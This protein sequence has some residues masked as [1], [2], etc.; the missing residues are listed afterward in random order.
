MESIESPAPHQLHMSND[1]WHVDRNVSYLSNVQFILISILIPDGI[2][3]QCVRNIPYYLAGPSMSTGAIDGVWRKYHPH[4][5]YN[6]YMYIT[7]DPLH[8]RALAHSRAPLFTQPWPHCSHSRAPGEQWARLCAFTLQG[9]V[10]A[11]WLCRG[12]PVIYIYIQK[13]IYNEWP[14]LITLQSQWIYMEIYRWWWVGRHRSRGPSTKGDCHCIWQCEPKNGSSVSKNL[15]KL[16]K[17][18]FQWTGLMSQDS[19]FGV[20]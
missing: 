6:I 5:V 11:A 13:I 16:C 10:Q 8:S 7:G 1:S 20:S 2:P 18:L 4:F 12:S 14:W 15:T 3:I 19:W 17:Q 9:C